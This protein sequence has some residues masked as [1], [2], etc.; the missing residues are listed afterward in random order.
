[1]AHNQK[2]T[3]GLNMGTEKSNSI[4]GENVKIGYNNISLFEKR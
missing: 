4:Y 1:M 3:E 2:N